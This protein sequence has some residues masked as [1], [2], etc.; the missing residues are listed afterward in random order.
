MGNAIKQRLREWLGITKPTYLRGLTGPQG[1]R[2]NTGPQG[3]DGPQGPSGE[4]DLE[5]RMQILALQ[6]K[7]DAIAEA[8]G[9]VITV[10]RYG[11]NPVARIKGIQRDGILA[12]A[13]IYLEAAHTA[14]QFVDAIV[15]LKARSNHG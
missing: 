13:K 5:T 15:A 1:D 9:I 11:L 12:E 14:E 7:F 3:R 6:A 4:A 10:D 8:L 2:G